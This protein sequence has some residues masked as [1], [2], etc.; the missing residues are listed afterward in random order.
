[1][2]EERVVVGMEEGTVVGM[3]VEGM[4]E[5]GMEAMMVVLVVVMVVVERRWRWWR[6]RGCSV[7]LP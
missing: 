7:D 6:R 2:E 5:V 1:M 3:V 4:E